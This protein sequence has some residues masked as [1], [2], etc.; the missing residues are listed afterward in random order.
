MD[1]GIAFKLDREQRESYSEK[2]GCVDT[3]DGHADS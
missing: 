2:Y 3:E 1:K